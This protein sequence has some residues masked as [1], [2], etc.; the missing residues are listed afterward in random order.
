MCLDVTRQMECL[1]GRWRQTKT[2]YY[3]EIS[4]LVLFSFFPFFF[5]KKYNSVA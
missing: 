1:V 5:K 4:E 2:N 3:E